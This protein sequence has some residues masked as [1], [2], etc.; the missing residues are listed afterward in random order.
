MNP[1]RTQKLNVDRPL[2]PSFSPQ[3]R[4]FPEPIFPG[5]PEY[6]LVWLPNTHDVVASV[7]WSSLLRPGLQ[8]LK[9]KSCPKETK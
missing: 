6:S 3:P 4:T 9:I 5:H 2:E 1:G 7:V 8:S